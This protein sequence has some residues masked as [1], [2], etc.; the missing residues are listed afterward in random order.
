M[1]SNLQRPH[2]LANS[3]ML[4]LLSFNALVSLGIGSL[5]WRF[6]HGSD[7]V[8]ANF[9]HSPGFLVFNQVIAF[10]L[11]L[12]IFT[13]ISRLNAY[14][15]PVPIPKRPLGLANIVLIIIISLLIQP[16]M[17][18]VSGLAS[19]FLPNPVPS[20][21]SEI[22]RLPL[23]LA[24]TIIALVPAICEE[25]VVR[26]F[27]QARYAQLPV[28]TMALVNGLFF[29]IIHMNLHQFTY[30]FLI[31]IIF[32][33]MVYFT[34]SVFAAMLSHFVL[35]A[36]Q[37][38]IVYFSPVQLYY[39]ATPQQQEVL[40]TLSQITPLVIFT[41]PLVGGLF[42]VFITYNRFKNPKPPQ[43]EGESVNKP[44]DLAFFAV[45]GLFIIYMILI[46]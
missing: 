2:N 32:A 22:V 37:L 39:V 3:F 12:A 23:P 1:F 26:G 9:L 29:G 20:L 42:Y 31:G 4:F 27:I 18:F 36:T 43:E 8:I 41:L 11:P 21:L 13:L 5:Y 14:Y 24:L 30:A 6:L 46:T 19:L 40:E 45:I 7:T 34:S 10:L 16:L 38:T 44:F 28:F 25:L 33:Y 17:M 15:I 35:N